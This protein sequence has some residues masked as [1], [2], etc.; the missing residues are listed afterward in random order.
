M[1][2]EQ[3]DRP[4]FKILARNDTGEAA[5]HQS[6]FVI[7]KDLDRFFP[8]LGDV[9]TAGNPTPSEQVQ[10]ALYIGDRFLDNVETRYQYQTWGGTR[11]P[12]R[13]MT[14]NLTPLLSGAKGG[15]LLIIQRGTLKTDQY[16]LRLIKQ[17]IPEFQS[18]RALTGNNRWGLLNPADPPVSEVQVRLALVE[19][20]SH[21]ALPFNAFDADAG[22][23]ET[24]SKRIAR[25]RAFQKTLCRIYGMKCA[26][27][28]GGLA[29]NSGKTEGE[30]AHI[31]PRG[32]KGSDDARNGLLLCRAHHWAFDNGLLGIT[33][34]FRV[35]VSPGALAFPA[36]DSLK[37]LANR[38]LLP[39][40][41]L[42]L[43]PH[44]DALRWH[45]KFHKLV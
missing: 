32:L 2:I 27:C 8:Q 29:K 39:P 36:N 31:V 26:I 19:Q 42:A 18:L 28:G 20:A 43:A 13:R 45:R 37:Q 41:D 1:L 24:R 5:G 16:L 17:A 33:D 30:G 6:G 21:E 44:R 14:G 15:D 7:P 11:S 9:A 22:V 4:I 35:I 38:Q 10:A 25:G 12:E 3:Y 40:S 34:N 23:S